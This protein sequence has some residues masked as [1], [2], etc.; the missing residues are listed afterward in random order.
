[1][2]LHIE[3]MGAHGSLLAYLLQQR[4]LPFT[5]NDTNADFTAWRAST[6]AVFPTGGEDDQRCMDDW[7]GL[8]DSYP[9]SVWQYAHWVFAAKKP[10]HNATGRSLPLTHDGV[11]KLLEG[12]QSLHCDVQTL[13]QS[14]QTD[15]AN[16]RCEN[17]PDDADVLIKAHGWTR[18][19][20]HVYW[21]WTRLVKLEHDFHT[22]LPGLGS[23]LPI[24][25][26]ARVNRFG[27]RYAYPA[28]KSGWWYAGS[29]IT[30]Q[31]SPASKPERFEKE[32][33]RWLAEFEE[34][35]AGHIRVV[36]EARFI[37]GWRPASQSMH[38]D[39]PNAYT[40][41]GPYEEGGRL[42]Y[43][44]PPMSHDGI[45]RFPDVWRWFQEELL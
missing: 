8:I 16:R 31:K 42:T 23:N 18:R 24:S 39:N 27:I 10:P 21:G 17:P 43:E 19:Q 26:Y 6:G 28:G 33:A 37:E 35:F 45:R 32:Y 44:T 13:V 5:W 7:R 2:K 30:K 22:E 11:V 3:G 4:G 25:P 29:T 38:G 14:A 20:T 34:A 41:L 15:F 36:E 1:M 9:D 40:V 12:S